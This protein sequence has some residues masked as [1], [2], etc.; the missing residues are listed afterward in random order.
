MRH[1]SHPA[2]AAAALLLRAGAVGAQ[3]RA[4][5]MI[6]TTN[7]IGVGSWAGGG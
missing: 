7:G 4:G 5:T 3:S 1:H 2:H 6:T